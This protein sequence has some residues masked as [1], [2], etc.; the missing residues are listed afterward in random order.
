MALTI[1][2][3]TSSIEDKPILKGINL[4]I[5]P[6]EIHAIMG[7]NGSG[8][9]TLANILM[10]NPVYTVTGGE[11]EFNGVDLLS[12]DVHHRAL[13]GIFLAFQ[14]PVEIPGVTLGKF[15]IRAKQQ[16][17]GEEKVKLGPF[18]KQ[19]KENMR[20]LDLD[21][22][23]MSRYLNEGFSGG[24]KKRAEIL[25]L[26]TLNP[27]L[28]ILDETDSGLDIDALK[29]VSQGINLMRGPDFSALIITHYQ[30]ILN[31]VRPDFVHI[32]YQGR[33]LESGDY[34][35]V[36]RL[37]KEGYDWIREKYGI[38]EEFTEAERVETALAENVS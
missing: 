30:R 8:K 18:I 23:F 38:Q 2:G 12:M 16:F 28:A 24:E 36:D 4:E 7:P 29:V 32:L 11:V 34:H 14:Y 26:L 31:L 5:R 35:L 20:L 22:S 9:S 3:L 27:R 15:L 21:E 6:G 33:I 37:E 1:K 10:G 19:V 25:Q 13:A 17:L